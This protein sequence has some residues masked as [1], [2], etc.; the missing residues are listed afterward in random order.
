[1]QDAEKVAFLTHPTPARGSTELA[2]VRD[3]PFPIRRS[4]IAQR[5]NEVEKKLI[6]DRKH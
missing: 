2:E 3:A 5:L 4:R 6:G 1:M